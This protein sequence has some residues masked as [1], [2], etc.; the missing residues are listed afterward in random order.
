MKTCLLCL[1]FIS[2]C[3]FLLMAQVD[4][5]WVRGYNGPANVWDDARVLALDNL[6]NVYV[7]GHGEGAE[8]DYAKMKYKQTT[9]IEEP[10]V[11]RPVNEKKALTTTMFQG[12]RILPVGKYCETF[13][14][15]GRIV[16]P[17][18]ITPAIIFM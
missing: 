11:F 16:D 9:A 5:A 1:M 10:P 2:L 18:R 3:L 12:P 4:T 15:T 8:Q 14:I 7:T 17:T 13:D 6:G